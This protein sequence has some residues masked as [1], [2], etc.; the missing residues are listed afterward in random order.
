MR[1]VLASD[2]F[3]G[4]LSAA[5]VGDALA[6]GLRRVV[7]DV[8][9]VR[10]PVAD[11]GDGTLVACADAGFELVPVTVE[12]PTGEVVMTAFARR[13][14]VAVVELADASGLARLGSGLAPL[15]A[16]TIGTGQ[17]LLPR[18]RRAAA[19]SCSASAAAR[20]PTAGSGC[21]WGWARWPATGRHHST[22][23]V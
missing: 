6:R 21:W 17:V 20:R 3:K 16:S 4:S 18:W 23:A 7:A 8:D 5:E 13:G 11:G 15:E 19:R 9:A 1:I 14:D 2:K 22:S 10:V 12:G